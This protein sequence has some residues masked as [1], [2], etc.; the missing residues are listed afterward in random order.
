MTQEMLNFCG[1]K[2][3]TADVEVGPTSLQCKTRANVA[4]AA[5]NGCKLHARACCQLLIHHWLTV[6]C[7]NMLLLLLLRGR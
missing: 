5:A 4:A 7:H 3:I 6:N 1:E 2:I